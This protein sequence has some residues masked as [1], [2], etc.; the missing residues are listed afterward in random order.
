MVER[1]LTGFENFS[2]QLER[3]L[4]PEV[5]KLLVRLAFGV[6]LDHFF[7]FLSFCVCVFV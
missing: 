4:L 1:V 2:V 7:F 3:T 5:G 6:E